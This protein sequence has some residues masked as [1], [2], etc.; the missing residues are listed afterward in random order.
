MAGA[1]LGPH[2]VNLLEHGDGIKLLASGGLLYIM[3]WAGLEINMTSFLK[4]RHKSLTFG[5]L[6]FSLPL[7]LGG[8]AALF[9][10]GFEPMGALL[11]AS[12]FSTHTLISYPI[13][14]RLRISQ[15]E[16]VAVTVGGTIITDTLALLLLAIVAG[17]ERGAVDGWFWVRLTLSL[18]AFVAVVLGLLPK[19]AK[20][21]FRRVESDLTYQYVFVLTIVFGCGLMAELAGVEAIIGAFM[22][23]LVLNRLIPHSSPLMNRIEFAGNAIF[24]PAFLFN[25][26]ML[27]NLQVF[28][29]GGK[30]I[31]AAVLLTAIALFTKWF[32]AYV[33]QKIFRYSID[34]R[35]LVF[36]LSSSHAAATIAI[37]LIGFEIKLFD[38]EVLNAT[39]FLILVTCLVSSF[40]TDRVARKLAA[41]GAIIPLAGGKERRILV[42]YANPASLINLVD[43]AILL[44]TPGSKEPIHPL[45]IILDEKDVRQKI[46]Q[47]HRLMEPALRHAA[48]RQA[49]LSPIHRVDV[50]AV[51]GILRTSNELLATDIVIGWRPVFT[52][53]EK[54]FGALHD[55]LLEESTEQV[56]VGYFSRSPFEFHQLKVLL[57]E[58]AQ[59]EPG[60][61]ELVH[62][63]DNLCNNT[64]AA[65]T[66]SANTEA[67]EAFD[68]LLSRKT[69]ER[70]Q[71]AAWS[72]TAWEH[73]H[74]RL[75]ADS[76]PILVSARKGGISHENYMDRQPPY[77]AEHFDGRSFVM[78]FP[79]Y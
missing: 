17:V 64:G 45:S 2:G 19:L 79:G 24:I 9:L 7:T 15:N 25:V 72:E 75:P 54:L 22:A 12:M 28:F 8:F 42:P 14:N 27:V 20:W 66:L 50:S 31:L 59:L 11:L 57:P 67:A 73:L 53:T 71:R 39:I 33:T 3:F 5:L 69:K 6:T 23:G 40:V 10:L 18:A 56:F 36:G 38:E 70:L 4:N 74:E 16:A 63:I 48:E 47:S 55:N 37:I 52:T 46:Q 35:N 21:F 30:T 76:L 32:A 61:V 60:F 34:Q 44:K 13:V 1:A 78:A 77:L 65:L 62:C 51:S 26:G 68:K 43:F 41:E 29:K 58:K 49:T